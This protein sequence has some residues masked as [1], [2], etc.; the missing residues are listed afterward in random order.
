MSALEIVELLAFGGVSLALRLVVV[1]LSRGRAEIDRVA[2]ELGVMRTQVDEARESTERWVAQLE[3]AQRA[4]ARM[5]SRAS[6]RAVAETV[7]DEIRAI[8]DYHACRVYVLEEPDDLVPVVAAG[9]NGYETIALED[10]RLRVGEGFSGWV[11]AN[12][13]PLLVPDATTDPRG[14]TIPGTD[15]I[16][17]SMLVVPMRYDERVTGVITL[18]K[19]GL[20]QFDHADVRIVSIL[21]DQAA[22]AVES[23]RAITASAALAEDLRRIADISS[24]LSH[25][26]DPRQVARLIAQHIGHAFEAD[27]CGI[28]SWDRPG[29]RLLTRGYWPPHRMEDHGAGL[30]ARRLPRDAA[31]PRDA[32]DLDDRHARPDG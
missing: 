17:E 10:L 8:V 29:D 4:A 23:A 32:D 25:S 31:G 1:R 15:E 6:V 3:V 20:R 9:E 19:L 18:S 7:A 2:T 14:V 5:A 24:A 21:A 12:G 28:S 26:L 13:R 22:T 11:A 27:E 30:R 16:E